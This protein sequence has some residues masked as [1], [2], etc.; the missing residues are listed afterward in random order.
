MEQRLLIEQARV[1]FGEVVEVV[2]VGSH[3]D[4]RI[5]EMHEGAR[6]RVVIATEIATIVQSE[7]FESYDHSLRRRCEVRGA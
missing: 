4:V 5:N 6:Q 1:M 7:P 3:S 2:D